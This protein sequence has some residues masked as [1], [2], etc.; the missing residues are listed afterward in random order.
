[1]IDGS[2]VTKGDTVRLMTA[3]ED[4]TIYYTLDGSDLA[5]SD[6]RQSYDGPIAISVDMRIRAYAIK[7]GYEDGEWAIFSYRLDSR[8]LGGLTL[9]RCADNRIEINGMPDGDGTV[10]VSAYTDD[11]IMIRITTLD[12]SE[13]LNTEGEVA[14]YRFYLVDDYLRPIGKSLTIRFP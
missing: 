4:A 2:T 8:T 12:G 3:M 1:M 5:V 7:D 6:N 10:C 9:T 11:G 14:Y 13:T